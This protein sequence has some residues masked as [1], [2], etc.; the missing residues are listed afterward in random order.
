MSKA[1]WICLTVCFLAI[2]AL[3]GLRIWVDSPKHI[4]PNFYFEGNK[5]VTEY[6]FNGSLRVSVNDDSMTI[7]M[8]TE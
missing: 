6:R 7:E 1:A 2:G 3:V 5:E 8:I 4:E